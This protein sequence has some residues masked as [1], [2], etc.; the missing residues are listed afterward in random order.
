MDKENM[1]LDNNNPLELCK[2]SFG[3]SDNQCFQQ[4]QHGEQ[5]V[6]QIGKENMP[7]FS[8]DDLESKIAQNGIKSYREMQQEKKRVVKLKNIWKP[9]LVASIVGALLLG[10]GTTVMG[11]RYYV[12]KSREVDSG[13]NLKFRNDGEEVIVVNSIDDAYKSVEETLGTD[14]LK[15]AYIPKGMT[16]DELEIVNNYAK[17]KFTY[18]DNYVNY[19]ITKKDLEVV[20]INISDCESYINVNNEWL[21]LDISVGKNELKTKLP[22]YRAGFAVG[23]AF[24]NING[25]MEEEEIIKVIEGINYYE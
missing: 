10:M 13:K 1:N 21:D 19:I 6:E 5:Q 14:I 20:S 18:K 25:V 12:Y 22:E 24:Y 11:K 17:F 3:F 15:L 8:Y 23:D 9:L 16:F 7:K 2:E 4:Y